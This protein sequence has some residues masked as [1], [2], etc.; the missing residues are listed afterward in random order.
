MLSP[1]AL[2]PAVALMQ[3]SDWTGM[4]IYKEDFNSLDPTPG[5]TRAKDSASLPA[6]VLSQFANWATGG[7]DYKPGR[8]SPTP[9]QIDF[10]TGQVT[11]GLGREILKAMQVLQA[12]FSDDELPLHKVPL[13]GRVIGS[14]SGQSGEAGRFYAAIRELNVLGSELD[15][16]I[17][18]GDD[19]QDFMLENPKAN[20]IEFGKASYNQVKKLRKLRDQLS[21]AGAERDAIN[22]V[23]DQITETMAELNKAMS[24]AD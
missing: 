1:T 2:D 23:N 21:D 16:R 11:G 14:T 18:S 9:D 10:I 7:N 12:P 22:A 6:K 20:L 15:G 13:V 3:N 5:H 4:P 17:K 24:E 19:P 8:M